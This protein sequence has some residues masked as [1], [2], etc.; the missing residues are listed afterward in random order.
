MQH[1]LSHAELI[2]LCL[3]VGE[4]CQP[5]QKR[6]KRGG[7]GAIFW[8]RRFPGLAYGR[9]DVLR[10]L[11]WRLVVMGCSRGDVEQAKK[12]QSVGLEHP[13]GAQLRGAGGEAWGSI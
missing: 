9:E 5:W 1:F 6:C 10:S 2:E 7:L 4:L 13:L 12:V 11:W 8:Y 3:S